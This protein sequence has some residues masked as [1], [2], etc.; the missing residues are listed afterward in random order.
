MLNS[1][2]IVIEV[3]YGLATTY[4]GLLTKAFVFIYFSVQFGNV[5]LHVTNALYYF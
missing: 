1:S 3:I 2:S 5:I 4:Q